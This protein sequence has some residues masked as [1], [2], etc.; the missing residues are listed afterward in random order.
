MLDMLGALIQPLWGPGKDAFHQMLGVL[1]DRHGMF[2]N[3]KI[4]AQLH[5]LT[6]QDSKAQK[7]ELNLSSPTGSDTYRLCH[8]LEV[9]KGQSGKE[10]HEEDP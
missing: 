6:L 1:L 2:W 9:P 7:R 8:K 3:L 10:G 5:F 4:H